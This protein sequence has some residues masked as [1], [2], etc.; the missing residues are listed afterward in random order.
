DTG[1]FTRLC[2][3]FSRYHIQLKDDT[4][5]FTR[6]CNT[7]RFTGGNN[8]KYTIPQQHIVYENELYEC[9]YEHISFLQQDALYE[10]FL[11]YGGNLRNYSFVWMEKK[12]ICYCLM[13][14]AG[15]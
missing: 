10:S 6:T 4:T 13:Y 5:F 1:S 14:P 3:I 2:N 8:L 7:M 9:L 11:I 15:N 12:S